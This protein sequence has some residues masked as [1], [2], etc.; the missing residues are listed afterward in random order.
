MPT[1]RWPLPVGVAMVAL[2]W[3]RSAVS[4]HSCVTGRE[5][6]QITK[7]ARGQTPVVPRAHDAQDLHRHAALRLANHGVLLGGLRVDHHTRSRLCVAAQSRLI[8]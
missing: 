2:I 4:A 1:A 3:M 8:P 5:P 7:A 6:S